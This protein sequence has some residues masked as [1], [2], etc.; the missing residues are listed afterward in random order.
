MT[1]GR[2][3][4]GRPFDPLEIR[5]D[6]DDDLYRVHSGRF[7]AVEFN[8]GRGARSRFAFFE[9]DGG[10]VPVLYAAS[11]P[12]AA[13]CETILH[14]LPPEE[15]KLYPSAF[16]GRVLSRLHPARGLRLASLTSEGLRRLRTRASDVTNTSPREYGATVKWA[17]AAFLA[18]YD[19]L[20][21]VS[22]KHNESY[23]YVF[24]GRPGQGAAFIQD[25][26]FARAFGVNP[27]DDDW[28]VGYCEKL[29]ISVIG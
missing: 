14:D 2:P 11:T 21:W 26:G 3:P 23:A 24:F 8:P 28:L 5:L 22:D 18:G 19:G 20:A 12:E 7:Q 10:T 15:A 6:Q 13:V 9:V 1:E 25:P 4:S 29:G 27:A 17:E 16:N